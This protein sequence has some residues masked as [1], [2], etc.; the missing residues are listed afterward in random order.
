MTDLAITLGKV[1]E[2]PMCARKGEI[3]YTFELYLN[4]N[5][6]RVLGKEGA[7]ILEA[8]EKFGSI[9]AAAK[10]LKM[11]YR[12]A[13]NYLVRMGKELG[14]LVVVTRRGGT[15]SARKK[16]GGGTSLTP[17][18]KALLKEF[19]QT[20]RIMRLTLSRIEGPSATSNTRVQ[21]K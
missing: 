19:K 2:R 1:N 13:W 4:T 17:V 16:G 20:E 14:Q 11:S 5:G 12:F 18:A 15:P 7:E 9:K 6:R 3:E 21:R 8:V 10:E